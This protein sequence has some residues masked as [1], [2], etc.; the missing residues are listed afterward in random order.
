MVAMKQPLFQLGRVVSTPDALEALKNAGQQPWEF[1]SRHSQGDWGN[2]SKEDGRLND[3]SVKD[4]S[5]ILSVFLL[6][7]GVKIWII[8]E[9]QDDQGQREVT[10]ILLADDY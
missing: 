4:G 7:T 9:A 10:T 5:R 6:K 3:E 2:L 1:I 8:T